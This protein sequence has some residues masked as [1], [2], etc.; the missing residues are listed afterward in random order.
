M[1]ITENMLLNIYQQ[2]IFLNTSWEYLLMTRFL[3]LFVIAFIDLNLVSLPALSASYYTQGHADLG[4]GDGDALELHLHGH[5]GLTYIDGA[6]IPADEEF[7]PTDVVVLVPQ[8]SKEYIHGRGGATYT[9]AQNLGIGIEE[10]FWFL[11]LWEGGAGGSDN[12]HS[13]FFGIGA[14]DMAMG[15]FIDDSTDLT[16]LAKA[17]SIQGQFALDQDGPAYV[18]TADEI[19]SDDKVSP[20]YIP[21]HDHF[22]WSFSKAGMYKLTFQ[23]SATRISTNLTETDT[24]TFTFLVGATIW[25][26]TAGGN[27]SNSDNWLTGVPDSGSTVIFTSSSDPNQPLTQDIAAPLDLHGII[28]TANAGSYQL[29]GQTIRLSVDSPEIT[30]ESASNQGIGNPLDLEAATTIAV[31]GSGNVT[32]SGAISGI[33]SFT[34]TG[35]GTLVLANV[36]THLGDTVIADGIL[37]LTDSGQIENSAIKNDAIFQIMAGDHS[38]TA[39]SGNGASMVLAG[40]LTADSI[41]QNT[42]TIS[43]GAR[44]TIAPLSAGPLGNCLTPVPEP[45]SWML[46]ACAMISSLMIYFR[47]RRP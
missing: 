46:L 36:A 5:A 39:I 25:K 6:V 22:K 7:V 44:V 21:T 28:F 24:N 27:W 3:S 45:S 47:R 4:L 35:S 10:D 37:A 13:P 16:L 2:I 30:S 14:E 18:I 1:E 20:F 41:V 26:G 19:T 32:L 29:G 34:K 23:A 33:G 15:V 38:V 8:S 40:S 12:L 17:G 11:P 42:L 43:A 9:E 31:N